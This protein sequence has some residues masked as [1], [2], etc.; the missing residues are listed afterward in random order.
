VAATLVR[1]SRR[2]RDVRLEFSSGIF[3]DV[4]SAEFDRQ[5]DNQS[6]QVEFPPEALRVL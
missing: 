5:K 3:A 2:V 1:I 4:S 6:W